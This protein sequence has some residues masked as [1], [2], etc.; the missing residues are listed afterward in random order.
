MPFQRRQWLIAIVLV[1]TVSM[2]WGQSVQA[3]METVTASILSATD[4]EPMG[5][6]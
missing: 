5:G 2:S 3:Q 1:L 4:M 6:M